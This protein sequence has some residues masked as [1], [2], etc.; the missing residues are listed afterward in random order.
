MGLVLTGTPSSLVWA[1]A[2]SSSERPTVSSEH[3]GSA[4]NGSLAFT[5]QTCMVCFSK[6]REGTRTRTRSAWSFSLMNKEVRVFPVPQAM[7]SCPR[8]D[9]VNPFTTSRIASR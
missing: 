7:M 9:F 5:R 3:T 1:T 4:A 6:D 8:S 2:V